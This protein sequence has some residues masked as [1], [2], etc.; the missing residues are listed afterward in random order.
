MADWMKTARAFL[1]ADGS[2]DAREVAVLRKELFADGQV[3]EAE[4][5]F[6]LGLWRGAKS[7]VPGFH[8]LMIDALKSCCLEGGALRPTSISLLRHWLLTDK[9]GYVE[10]RYLDELRAAAKQVPPE[11]ER[12]CR[13]VAG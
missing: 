3:D 6:L 2:I 13:Q 5:D 10:K 9:P 11:F 4:L 12:L 7:V 1:L 8:H